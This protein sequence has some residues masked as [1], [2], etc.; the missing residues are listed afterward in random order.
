MDI[1]TDIQIINQAALDIAAELAKLAN[2]P[3]LDQGNAILDA[4]GDLDTQ[5]NNQHNKLIARMRAM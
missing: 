3:A 2:I 1:Q 5:A 4:I